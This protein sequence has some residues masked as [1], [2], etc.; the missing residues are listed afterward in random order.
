MFPTMRH[1][2]LWLKGA[3]FG[4]VLLGQE[5]LSADTAARRFCFDKFSERFGI[6]C[7]VEACHCPL[8]IHIRQ[9]QAIE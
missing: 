3:L 4:Y 2:L 6:A 1:I 9:Q 8:K 7:P 5:E